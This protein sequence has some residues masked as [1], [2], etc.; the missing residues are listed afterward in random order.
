[1]RRREFSSLGEGNETTQIIT[2]VGGAAVGWPLA[3]LAQP[4]TGT[5]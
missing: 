5:G 1:M 3:A 2:L 4:C